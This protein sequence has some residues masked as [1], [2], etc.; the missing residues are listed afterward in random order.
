MNPAALLYAI[1]VLNALPSLIAT[2]QN[3]L[4]TVQTYRD[5]MERMA[6]EKRDPT[7]EEWAALN[8]AID[9]QRALLHKPVTQ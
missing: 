2:G 6:A 3:V 7:A 8:S 4:A 1:Q 9:A 5:A